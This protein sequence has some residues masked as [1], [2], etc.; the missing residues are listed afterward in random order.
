M[1]KYYFLIFI[2]P[3]LSCSLKKIEYY[4]YKPKISYYD[5]GTI[6]SVYTFKKI[7]SKSCENVDGKC[8]WVFVKEEYYDNG[9][10]KSLEKGK[11][12]TSGWGE[13]KRV[14][15]VKYSL[16]GTLLEKIKIKK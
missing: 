8:E 10:L 2:I 15:L 16:D 3:F 12:W 9:S 13:K 14:I 11:G 7:K 6:K 4:P 5:N 1:Y